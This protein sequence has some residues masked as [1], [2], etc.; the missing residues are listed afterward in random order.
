MDEKIICSKERVYE[1]DGTV[2][3]IIREFENCGCTILEQIITFL[4]DK[5]NKEE[6]K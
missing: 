6:N 2:I 4:I 5:M 1:E 3:T